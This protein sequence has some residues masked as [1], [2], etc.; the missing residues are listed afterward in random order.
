MKALKTNK[1]YSEWSFGPYNVRYREN[2]KEEELTEG[3]MDIF[4]LGKVYFI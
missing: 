3:N 1:A 2:G 4:V